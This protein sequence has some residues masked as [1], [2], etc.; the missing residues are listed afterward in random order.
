MAKLFT[1]YHWQFVVLLTAASINVFE[2][3][4]LQRKYDLF[5]GG[6]LTAFSYV[7]F[8]QKLEFLLLT[9]LYDLLVYGSIAL[10]WLVVIRRLH[11]NSLLHAYYYFVTTVFI[12]MVITAS[13]YQVLSYF[14]DTVNLAVIK[15]LGGGSLKEALLYAGNELVLAFV[16]LGA[17]VFFML[18]VNHLVKRSNVIKE[19][20]T[21]SSPY[22]F[23]SNKKIAITL[24]LF[25][26]TAL[27]TFYIST[28]DS[29]NYGMKKKLSYGLVSSI[30]DTLT[31]FD[32]DGHGLFISPHDARPFNRAVY[33]GALDIPANGIDED[34]LLGD[35]PTPK[36]VDD[37]L[38]RVTIHH[39]KHIILIVL[40]STRADELVQKINGKFVAPHIGD[41]SIF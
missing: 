15:N 13:R 41:E 8:S 1:K 34:G 2:L 40:E 35:A 5:S 24:L 10:L 17:A 21:S 16:L 37:A 32:R 39:K 36:V 3:L 9:L 20:K 27:L 12:L 26:I 18:I 19:F 29:L 25:M 38:K 4:L 7:S 30:L 23:T 6:F 33:P 31:D 14:S 11:K 22:H 28:V